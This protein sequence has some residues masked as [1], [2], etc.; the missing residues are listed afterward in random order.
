MT[1]KKFSSIWFE[2]SLIDDVTLDDEEDQGKP[3]LFQNSD[4]RKM[5][6]LAN[7]NKNDV[8]FDL[9]CGWGQNLI[10]A[11]TEFNVK[12][13]IGFEYNQERNKIAKRR[14]ERLVKIGIKANR[15]DIRI[16]DFETDL[17]NEKIP[18]LKLS[19]ATVVFY[20]LSTSKRLFNKMNHR[21]ANGCRLICYY[22]C[23]FPEIVP[24]KNKI[25]FP[26]YVHTFPF[27]K[28]SSEQEWL[29]TIVMKKR[30]T[31]RKKKNPSISELWDE[32]HHDYDINY[33]KEDADDYKDRMKR[34]LKK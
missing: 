15:Y 24:D 8:F 4:I 19:D 32:I 31:L 9:G 18:G 25:D 1:R 29:S 30:S 23:L 34:L 6:K 26:F 2:D 21:F 22:D 33:H 5:L 27:K 12:K 20:G 16:E 28:T 13:G 14:L 10:I 11:L 17:L 3:I 7:V